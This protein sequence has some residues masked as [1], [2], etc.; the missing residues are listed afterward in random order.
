MNRIEFQENLIWGKL[1]NDKNL[2]QMTTYD[3]ISYW[4]N[5]DY[6]FYS[7][8]RF[9]TESKGAK[10]AF[11]W[12]NRLI[13][14]YF[15]SKIGIYIFLIFEI[16][17][18]LYGKLIV[19]LVILT[20]QGKKIPREDKIT[21]LVN[22]YD[23]AWVATPNYL[24]KVVRKSDH[25]KDSA[26]ETLRDKVFF[27]CT[28]SFRYRKSSFKIALDRSLFWKYSYNLLNAYWSPRSWLKQKKAFNHYQKQWNMLRIDPEF[29][30]LCQFNN[31]DLS[32]Y[33]I[34]EFHYYFLFLLPLCHS[35][36]ETYSTIMRSQNISLAFISNETGHAERS[37][38]IAAKKQGIPVLAMQHGVISPANRSYIYS[39]RDVDQHGSIQSPFCILPDKIAVF[40]SKYRDLLVDQ[41]NIPESTVVVT[42]NPKFDKLFQM[43]EQFKDSDH[44]RK[45]LGVPRKG[46][47]LV[48]TT[49]T[50][51]LSLEENLKNIDAVYSALEEIDDDIELIIKLHPNEDQNAPLYHQDPRIKPI[52][53][54]KNIDIFQL[55]YISD[56]MLTKDSMT[57]T[58]AIALNKPL[59]LLN[60]SGNPDI[61]DCVEQGVA[62][63][64]Y[65]KEHLKKAIVNLL[66]DDGDL[67]RNREKYILSEY[68]L[69]DGKSSYRMAQLIL[70]MISEKKRKKA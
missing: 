53:F 1:T 64:I 14:N 24:D 15:G 38:I 55:I 37:S 32:N 58:E 70:S 63:G 31:F 45:W 23:G 16:C 7:Y 20:Q 35:W 13:A 47:I 26:M 52:V 19:L 61:I 12:R 44:I 21:V 30:K 39:K 69:I 11:S 25:L 48:W 10:S 29:K 27:T 66:H 49:Q 34:D 54:G 67:A 5:I 68:H 36:V 28:S 57:S 46:K 59:I 4:W 56:L 6:L 17:L 50:H 65:K 51:G 43:V 42:G 22:S 33:I 62:K 9:L 18:F 2:L 8:F 3:G 40:G 41:G 60:L